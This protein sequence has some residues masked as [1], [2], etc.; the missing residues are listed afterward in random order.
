MTEDSIDACDRDW[1]LSDCGRLTCR[2]RKSAGRGS[3]VWS[4]GR[5]NSLRQAVRN[6]GDALIECP[7]RIDGDCDCRGAA[8]HDRQVF[9]RGRQREVP[10]GLTVRAIVVVTMGSDPR[11]GRAR[12]QSG[13]TTKARSA[14]QDFALWK[15]A[16][17]DEPS[18][19]LLFICIESVWWVGDGDIK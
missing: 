19:P 18:S 9:W 13:A 10:N 1:K 5:C 6:Q 14:Y 2:Q 11:V 17:P 8:A 7:L 4:K 12:E 16:D 15:D 3:Y